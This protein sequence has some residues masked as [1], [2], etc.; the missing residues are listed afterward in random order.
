MHRMKGFKKIGITGI[1]SLMAISTV[2][3]Q[4]SINAQ[5][6]NRFEVRDGYQKLATDGAA[7]A[8]FISQRTRITFSYE[9]ENLRLKFTPQDVRVW[10][11]EQL[12]SSTGVF[13]DEASLDLFEG[14]AEIRTGRSG[15]LSIGR[16]QLVYDNERLL[17]A[18]N[19]NQTGIAYD[20]VVYKLNADGWD[21]HLGSSWNSTGENSADNL[22]EPARIKS[23]SFLWVKHTLSEGWDLSLSHIASGVT[24]SETENTLR[25]KQTTGLYT[26]YTKGDWNLWANAYYQFGKN[27]TGNNVSASLIDAEASLKTGEMTTG[28][29]IGYLSGNS[30][31]G[32]EQTTD[33]LFDILYGARHRVYGS[34]DYFRSPNSSTKQ[35]GLIDYYLFLNYKFSGKTSLRNTGH[36][37]Q[38][39]QTN[40]G[41]PDD[42]KLGY[43]NDILLKHQFYGWG[44]FEAGY[45]FFL[46]TNSLKTIQGVEDNK[47]SQFFYL[48]LTITPSLFNSAKSL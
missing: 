34:I 23:L 40:P 3:A 14:F 13:G 21:F 36:Y 35:G 22:Y 29:G 43:E 46:P 6:R 33:H 12:A 28:A 10:G 7:P 45:S 19:W 42:K 5:L 27:Q 17:A 25:F 15:W 41:T 48:Q 44:A 16:Q 30:K 11:D 2:Q 31:T 8:V 47:F 32:A 4:F 39:A 26:T 1:I 24:K 38:L 18:R 20:A 37:F 9:T